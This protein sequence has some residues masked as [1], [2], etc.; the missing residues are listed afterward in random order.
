MPRSRATPQR[1]EHVGRRHRIQ[2]GHGLVGE[3]ERALR[4]HPSDRHALLLTSGQ[5]ILPAITGL[6]LRPYDA[7]RS[8][9][10]PRAG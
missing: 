2:A 3:H 6:L 10:S 4:Q 8:A 9:S 7:L 1:V 5:A